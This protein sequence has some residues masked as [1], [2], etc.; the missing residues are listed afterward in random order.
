MEEASALANKVAILAKRMLAVGTTSELEARYATY[1]VHFSVRT[2][3]EAIRAKQIMSRVP[4]ARAAE[5]VATRFE[6]PVVR[7]RPADDASEMGIT[8]EDL[9]G[10]LAQEDLEFA[11]ERPM[12]ESVFLKVIREH[13]VEEENQSE[14]K[15]SIWTI[16]K[17]FI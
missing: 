11:V 2:P 13:N 12:L 14:A 9:F 5:D 3:E 7:T 1:E 16:L 8:L 6:V 10:I 4:G 15:K 17:R